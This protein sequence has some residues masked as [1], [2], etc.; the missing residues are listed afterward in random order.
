MTS[1]RK[2]IKVFGVLL[3][4]VLLFA[5]MPVGHVQADWSTFNNP[6][7]Y[8]AAITDAPEGTYYRSA[9]FN[10]DGSKIVAQKAWGTKRELVL[11]DADG[12]NEVVISPGDSGEGD[13]YA[14]M[15]PFWSD[16]GSTIGFVEVHNSNPN[17]VVAYDIATATPSYLY[18]PVTSDVANPDF[19]GS[20]TSTIVF[21][22]YGVGGN[23]ADLFIWDGATLTNITS[24]ADYKE[25]EPSSN[26]DGTKIVF[27]SGETT[28]E[29][30]NTTHTLTL[31]GGSWVKDVGFTPIPDSYWSYWATPAANQIVLTTMSEKDIDIYDSSGSFLADL[32]GD[33]Y[34]GGA[35]QWNFFGCMP[36]GP[37]GEFVITSNAE[38]TL[39]GRDIIIANPRSTLYVS[40]A[41][42]DDNPGTQA[43]PFATIQKA[44]DEAADGATIH[45]GAGEYAENVV[46]DK[47]VTLIGAGSGYDG[48]SD[49][50]VISGSGDILTITAGGSD[51]ASRQVVKNLQVTNKGVTGNGLVLVDGTNTIAHL[52][53]DNV[54]SVN[55]NN[56]ILMGLGKSTS[57]NTKFEDI[58]FDSCVF[59]ENASIGINPGG[60][61]AIRGFDLINCNANQNGVAGFQ[62]YQYSGGI[63]GITISGGS[64]GNQGTDKWDNSGIYIGG[65][66]GNAGLNSNFLPGD[67]LPNTFENFDVSNTSRGL[68]IWVF[69]DSAISVKGI[70]GSNL[71]FAGGYGA[72]SLLAHNTAANHIEIKDCTFSDV[73]SDPVVGAILVEA[74]YSS[75]AV[76]Y[77]HVTF[78][79]LDQPIIT[80]CSVSNS[81]VG[82]A[83]RAT[84][85]TTYP[86]SRTITNANV[87]NNTLVGN[88]VGVSVLG[89]VSDSAIQTNKIFDNI[90]FG[91]D[92][93]TAT[94]TINASPNWWGSIAGPTSGQIVGDVE[95]KP[96][97]G[98]EA[99]TFTVPDGDG[100]IELSGN[101]NIPGG[102]IVD[103]PGLTFLLQDGTV[104]QND[105]PCFVINADNTK[106]TTASLGGATCVPTD[107][108]N[109]IDVAD[110]LTDIII[111]GIEIDG[112]GQDTGDGIHFAGAITD[113]ILRDN[114]IHDLDG[115]GVEFSAAPVG[116]VQ[117]QGNLFMDNAGVGVEAPAD[118]DVSYNAWGHYDGPASG[119][120]VSANITSFSPWTHVDMYMESSGTD[121]ADEVREG[122]TITYTIYAN[123]Q[124]ATGADFFVKFDTLLLEVSG[125]TLGS[126][127][128]APATGGDVVTYDNVT[129]KIH[130]AGQPDPF[131]AQ[132]GADLVL[133]T[134]TFTAKADGVTDLGFGDDN[135]AMSPPSGPSN[136]I[137]A[138]AL[139]D[140]SATVRNHYT[141]TATVSMQG[142]TVRSGVLFT[143]TTNT[144]IAWGPFQTTSTAP[145]SD[146]V[147]MTGVVE[148]TYDVTIDQDRYLDVTT[149]SGITVDVNADLTLTPLELFGGDV[150]DDEI[151]D[152]S[153]ASLIGANYYGTGAADA[154]FDGIVN[155]FDLALV[156]G[157]YGLESA[158]AYGSWT[159]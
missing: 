42:S 119:D 21:W 151:I 60:A 78:G 149:A 153:D 108:S 76:G 66:Y 126:V 7:Y 2:F 111:E 39:D 44:I 46:I 6:D 117:V 100:V 122:E 156:G 144:G 56:G 125:T 54:A 4:V 147:F 130:F 92:A 124:E 140:G 5:V 29:P 138:A 3:A 84:E 22:A 87:A 81:T 53:L 98:D 67:L 96:W 26:A 16:D 121:V 71:G 36:Q 94:S 123:L 109:G 155:I 50:T 131:A 97:C 64:Y 99:C 83:L 70:T 37:D 129:G 38:R 28:A 90:T 104:I 101:I 103:Q 118:L 1:K 19:L 73:T 58:V 13:I 114:F 132:S 102:I 133:F 14:Y 157:N 120:G 8:Y 112:S 128:D 95:F 136:N 33:G 65:Q 80:N 69:G 59:S 143:L 23:V 110:G 159:P 32:S 113:V 40:M 75:S 41:G 145:I 154:N 85:S 146:N 47:K 10:F 148:N 91:L 135:F 74:F 24:T 77:G 134:V 107:S 17:K 45:V 25:Y 89:L 15:N 105:S 68:F 34:S 57:Q 9:G 11:M 79:S 106:I 18:E 49:S 86:G 127:F 152:V 115:D 55:N 20:S 139:V 31:S 27:W 51:A 30:V 82:I 116:T 88:N 72:I 150:E 62:S 93:S 61:D 142:R 52:T 43:A 48:L 63:T 158:T 12:S 137:Y 141:V 35:G